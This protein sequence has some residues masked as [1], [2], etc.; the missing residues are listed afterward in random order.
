M[1]T[2]S[3]ALIHSKNDKERI[4]A[5]VSLARLNDPRSFSTLVTALR[6]DHRNVRAIAAVALGQLG[7]S[8]AL[9]ALREA[10]KDRD[11]MVRKRAL[12]AIEAIEK[13]TRYRV[14]SRRG[15]PGFGQSPRSVT[16]PQVY[17]V[18][19]SSADKT[20]GPAS[21]R[22]RDRRAKQMRRIFGKE[23]ASAPEITTSARMAEQLGIPHYALDASIVRFNRRTMGADIEIE[24]R[25]RVAISDQ[26]GKILS[27]L[28]SGA[29]VRVP[30]S[31]F[32]ERRSLPGITRDALHSAVKGI[33]RD[34][35]QYLI[36]RSTSS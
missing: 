5:A 14:S 3:R 10:A 29:R 4:S 17:V 18:L 26:R 23:M 28:T 19:K 31:G 33:K 22:D 35:L 11:R 9:P 30:K 13:K 8:R 27:F 2:L 24:C 7:V 21:Q 16:R 36:R 34:L 1:S 6:D 25:V 12:Q 20:T 15:E 32:D